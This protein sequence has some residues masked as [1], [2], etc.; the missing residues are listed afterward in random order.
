MYFSK[1]SLTRKGLEFL[2]HNGGSVYA[3]HKLLW[4][5]FGS[6]NSKRPFLF[7]PLLP[8]A[9][10]DLY[11]QSTVEPD[12]R[13]GYF[14]METKEINP[15]FKKG[16]VFSLQCLVNATVQTAHP[17]IAGEKG[18]IRLGVMTYEYLLSSIQ[19]RPPRSESEMM[20][21]WLDKRTEHTGMQMV[22]I[23]A[24][25]TYRLEGKK[26]GRPI[27]ADVVP[28]KAVVEVVDPEAFRRV[29]EKGLGRAAF[30][31]AGMM[32]LKPL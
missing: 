20:T 6:L 30:I 17:D 2:A 13:D 32:L 31:G 28:I 4:T 5:L 27:I 23:E 8:G 14:E 29:W 18:S 15:E 22:D 10:R 3:Q 25:S 26:K 21:E 12:N 1:A 11:I 19:D 16:Q 9:G 7:T 24:S